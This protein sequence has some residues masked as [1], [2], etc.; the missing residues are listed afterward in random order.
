MEVVTYYHDGVNDIVDHLFQDSFK[1]CLKEIAE[2]DF[3]ALE[4]YKNASPYSDQIKNV[5]GEVVLVRTDWKPGG[6]RAWAYLKKDGTLPEFF[7]D[8]FGNNCGKVP[9]RYHGEVK[10]AT[11]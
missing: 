8:A 4:H 2:L 3:E 10:K 9:A 7:T 11:A 5:R 6:V 1:G